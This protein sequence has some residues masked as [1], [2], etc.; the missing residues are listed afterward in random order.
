MDADDII[1]FHDSVRFQKLR[2]MA[3]VRCYDHNPVGVG[4]VR[5]L[6]DFHEQ[7]SRYNVIKGTECRKYISD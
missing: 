1:V 6:V 2:H 4:H 5:V 7:L 3:R